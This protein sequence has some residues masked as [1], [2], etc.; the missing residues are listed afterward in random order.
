METIDVPFNVDDSHAVDN[1]KHI[2]IKVHFPN[3]CIVL[4]T[5]IEAVTKY[6]YFVMPHVEMVWHRDEDEDKDSKPAAKA[7]KSPEKTPTK[8][9]KKGEA[10]TPKPSPVTLTEHWGNGDS[11]SGETE[12]DDINNSDSGDEDHSFDLTNAQLVALM[13]RHLRA[14]EQTVRSVRDVHE[15]YDDYA[16][17][18]DQFYGVKIMAAMEGI[19]SHNYPISHMNIRGI[20]RDV[21][22]VDG[23]MATLVRNL[24]EHKRFRISVDNDIQYQRIRVWTWHVDFGDDDFKYHAY[25]ISDGIIDGM[26]H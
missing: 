12:S 9:L 23:D 18:Q 7:S 10:T 3:T 26:S 19:R 2:K 1:P 20:M 14:V 5:M 16:F 11:G 4:F 21:E 8:K 17:L 24:I 13:M 25:G 15:D 6:N 22:G